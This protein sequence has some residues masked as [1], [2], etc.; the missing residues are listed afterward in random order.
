MSDQKEYNK[1]YAL[2]YELCRKILIRKR[3]SYGKNNNTIS[4]TNIET[5]ISSLPMAELIMKQPFNTEIYEAVIRKE[6]DTTG[7]LFFPDSA[8]KRFTTLDSVENML[9]ENLNQT[10]DINPEFTATYKKHNP[11]KTLKSNAW[12]EKILSFNADKMQLKVYDHERLNLAVKLFPD[13]TIPDIS[14]YNVM[15]SLSDPHILNIY[16]CVLVGMVKY[17]PV[18][19]LHMNADYRCAV[20]TRYLIRDLKG[21]TTPVEIQELDEFFF[22]ENKL[23]NVLRY[24]NYSVNQ[25]LVNTFPEIVRPW[26]NGRIK[27]N[28]W[29]DKTNRIAAVQWLVSEKLNI[30]I[31]GSAKIIVLRSDFTKNGLSYLYNTYYNAVSKALL[32]A[33]PQLEPWQVGALPANFWT[34]ANI[35]YAVNWMFKYLK[36]DTTALPEYYSRKKL[37]RKTFSRFGLSGLYEKVFNCNIYKLI[38]YVYPGKFM[39]WEFSY[40]SYSFWTQSSN[41]VTFGQ[42][43]FKKYAYHSQNPDLLD[44]GFYTSLKKF[45][46]GNINNFTKIYA[47]DMAEINKSRLINKKWNKLVGRE[48][49][50]MLG[51]ILVYG[52]FY[53][54][55]K[56]QS[57]QHNRQFKRMER[58]SRRLLSYT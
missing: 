45:C 48:N 32:E 16:K 33:Y 17:F 11:L 39:P 27:D 55:V 29:E 22:L 25:I 56:Q 58:R 46:G 6:M 42:W 54:M 20:I 53:S 30:D 57:F 31:R 44:N 51:N 24:F 52:I 23:L 8:K 43:F 18:N 21:L 5:V 9:I 38:N 10:I 13:G 12:L 40:V 35:V 49:L 1:R 15:H 14:Q 19:F 36:W 50:S 4:R 28:Y 2:A 47:G 7:K 26:M 41:R 34:Q 37:N 3:Y